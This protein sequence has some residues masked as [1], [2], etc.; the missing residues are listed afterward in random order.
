MLLGIVF[1]V[2]FTVISDSWI[3]GLSNK[4]S[5]EF[6]ERKAAYDTYVCFWIY[7]IYYCLQITFL[8]CTCVHIGAYW[9][10]G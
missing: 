4:D 3:A 8:A 2:Q 6:Q 7:T 9:S 10:S 1:K 5:K